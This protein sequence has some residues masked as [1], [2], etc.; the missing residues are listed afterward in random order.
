MSDTEKNKL[1]VN[2]GS[3]LSGDWATKCSKCGLSANQK[4]GITLTCNCKD[5]TG[6]CSA[7]PTKKVIVSPSSL[8]VNATDLV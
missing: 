5:K 2:I 6:A 4:D 1:S 7:K 3:I 8:S